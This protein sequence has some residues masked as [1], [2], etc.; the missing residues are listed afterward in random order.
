MIFK[1]IEKKL[2]KFDVLIIHIISSEVIKKML[3]NYVDYFQKVLKLELHS[4][5]KNRIIITSIYS[6]II[7]V[8]QNNER[9]SQ[10]CAYNSYNYIQNIKYSSFFVL[11]CM[12][13]SH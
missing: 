3:M 6:V 12:Y 13:Y 2:T 10:L 1:S 11:N 7:I 5:S 8:I 9:L 4:I